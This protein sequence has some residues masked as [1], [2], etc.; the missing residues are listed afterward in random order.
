MPREPV[1]L[2]IREIANQ[3]EILWTIWGT[4]GSTLRS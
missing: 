4:T 2:P 1:M 3:L